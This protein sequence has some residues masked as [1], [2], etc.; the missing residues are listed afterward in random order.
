MKRFFALLLSLL[1]LCAAAA[2]ESVTF[3]SVTAERNA[4]Y[5]DMGSQKVGAKEWPQFIAFLGEFPNLRRVDMFATQV[6]ADKVSLL[7]EAFPDVEFGWT[8]QLMKY[9]T[10]HI[11]RTD[12]EAF[13]TLHGI[14]PNHASSEFALLSYCTDLKALDLGH[15]NLTDITFLRNMP[16]LRVLILGENQKL[17]NIEV[18]GELK[19]LEYLELFTCGIVDITPLTGLTNLVDLNLANNRVADWRPL[20]QMTWL[21]R[22]WISR[23]TASRMSAAEQQELKDALPDTEI[24]FKGEPTDYGWRFSDK[25]N[26]VKVPHYDVIYRMFRGDRYIPFEESAPLPSGEEEEG[27]SPFLIT[28]DLDEDVLNP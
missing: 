23:M 18:I 8:L 16:H 11:V 14:C 9:K 10:R 15:N 22:L 21:R 4:D 1:L 6:T 26:T 2:A 27:V 28:E 19:E 12:A 3:G 17:K 20:K 5:L 24:V 13:S 25:K 7:K